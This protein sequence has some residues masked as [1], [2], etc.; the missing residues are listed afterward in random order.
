[1][2]PEIS[3][4]WQQ[5]IE[6]FSKWTPSTYVEHPYVAVAAVAWFIV[7]CLSTWA[8]FSP[9]VRDTTLERVALTG[10]AFGSFSRVFFVLGRGEI[11]WD[12]VLTSVSIAFYCIV[13]WHKNKYVIPKR[14]R[15]EE[16]SLR[17]YEGPN[18][19]ASRKT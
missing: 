12:G 5:T 1:M 8:I 3:L 10:I 13:I 17:A 6:A 2:T 7:G 15:K 4:T 16:E 11:P 19:R 14:K 9:R 18:R